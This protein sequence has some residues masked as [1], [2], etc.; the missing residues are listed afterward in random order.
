[1]YILLTGMIIAN[2]LQTWIQDFYSLR[3]SQILEMYY[4]YEGIAFNTNIRAC[5]RSEA[6]S[7]SV[8][9]TIL[10]EQTYAIAQ[11]LAYRKS[12]A[13]ISPKTLEKLVERA[14]EIFYN[15]AET[16]LFPELP[17]QQINH[18]RVEALVVFD[19]SW[20]VEYTTDLLAVLI[21]DLDVST[22]GSKIGIIHGTSGEWLL[23][24][25][26]SPSFAFETLTNFTNVS[27]PTEFNYVK[28]LNTIF[29]HLNKTWEN[30]GK[31]RIIGNLGQAVILLTPL[32]S[33]SNNDKLSAT[34]ILRQIKYNY[35]EVHFVYYTSRSNTDLFL[36]FI[37]SDEDRLIDNSNL[38]TVIRY[39][40]T[41]PKI[42]RSVSLDLYNSTNITSQF[43]D[44]ISPSESITYKINSKWKKD[45][46]KIS[47]TIHSFGYGSIK[48]CS[49][50]QFRSDDKER[51]Q[52]IELTGYEE[53]TLTNRLKCI[54]PLSCPDM[55]LQIRNVT[56]LYKCAEIDC[57]TPDQVRFILRMEEEVLR[58][59]NS[60]N[61]NKLV[62]FNLLVLFILEILI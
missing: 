44:Y 40:S 50:I 22:Y 19:G 41:I 55:Y 4:S 51:F 46:R 36:S 45:S 13:Y 2:N 16:H 25:T 23:N 62:L 21:Q 42:L 58:Y 53:V 3:L 59:E 20:P 31:H 61:K 11:M 26:S 28:V 49:W 35:P 7:Y 56:S 6:F 12:I 27:W 5:N 30:N 39:I 10:N 29:A 54:E 14:T 33:M 37:L 47:I 15:Y 24:V 32:G 8:P 60:A 18:S 38:D 1:M 9:K 57:K 48:A 52:C 43:E 34:T 17:C